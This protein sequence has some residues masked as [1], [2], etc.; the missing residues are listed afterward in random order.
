V[1]IV[2]RLTDVNCLPQP[3][4]SMLL[5]R[6][7]LL[8]FQESNAAVAYFAHEILIPLGDETHWN[9]KFRSD[10]TPTSETGNVIEQMFYNAFC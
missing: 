4:A 3:N 7:S 2:V 10:R 8:P 9:S 6:F 1:S 5:E